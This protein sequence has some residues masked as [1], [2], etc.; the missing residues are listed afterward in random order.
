MSAVPSTN[1][2]A[3]AAIVHDDTGLKTRGNG[4]RIKPGDELV[5]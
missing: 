2:P 5:Q 1:T 4:S 3:A